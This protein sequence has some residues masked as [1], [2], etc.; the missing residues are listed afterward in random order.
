MGC[1]IHCYVEHRDKGS[2]HW[3]GFGG[4]INPGRNYQMFGLLAGVRG[5]TALVEPRGVPENMAYDARDDYWLFINRSGQPGDGETTP[6]RAAKYVAEDG[7]EYVGHQTNGQPNWVTHPDWHSAS[8][9][10]PDEFQK[11]SDAAAEADAPYGL[12]SEYY[13]LIAAMREFEKR[14]EDARVVFWFDN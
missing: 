14:G 7:C 12:S 6:E 13:A 4:R 5:G 1:D 9:L 8:W 2:E 10:T 3:Y 11:A